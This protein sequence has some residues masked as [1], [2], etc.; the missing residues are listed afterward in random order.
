MTVDKKDIIQYVGKVVLIKHMPNFIGGARA[1]SRPTD[2][3]GRSVR[4]RFSQHWEVI[5]IHCQ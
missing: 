4:G 5:S 2:S 3:K 1:V